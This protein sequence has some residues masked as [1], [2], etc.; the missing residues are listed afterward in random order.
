MDWV[1]AI[2]EAIS[3]MESN[4]T[5]ERRNKFYGYFGYSLFGI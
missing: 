1:K 3:Y 5:E 4:L 2:N